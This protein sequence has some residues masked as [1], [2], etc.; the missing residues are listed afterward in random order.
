MDGDGRWRK[1]WDERLQRSEPYLI[2]LLKHGPGDPVWRSRALEP[3]R[4]AV[5]SLCVVGW[6][7]LFADG[8]VR[9]YEQISAPKMLLAG[10]WM[11]VQP[12]ASP[13]CAINFLP[14][15]LRWWDRWLRGVRNGVENE[16]PVTVFIQGSNQ[17]RSLAAWPPAEAR[18]VIWF[19]TADG[20]LQTEPTA[21]SRSAP[22]SPDS[23]IGVGAGLPNFYSTGFGLP[24]DQSDDDK[25]GITFTSAP[26]RA[27]IS[28]FGR[29]RLRLQL[30]CDSASK[31][32]VVAKLADVQP[33]DR[34]VFIT[35]GVS[36]LS[37]RGSDGALVFEFSPTSYQIAVG[38][39][40]RLT[41]S[42]GDFPRLWPDKDGSELL[43]ECGGVAAT[44]L[45]LLIATSNVGDE[46]RIEAA[47]SSDQVAPQLLKSESPQYDV[48]RDTNVGTVTVKLSMDDQLHSTDFVNSIR[49]VRSVSTSVS[50][51]NPESANFA[52]DATAEITTADGPI[53]IRAEVHVTEGSATVEGEIVSNEKTIFK[54]K[55]TV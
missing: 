9:A 25:R 26:V 45:H 18:S 17:W 21:V 32:T 11:H 47:N 49:Y 2:D 39:Q 46:T 22:K 40:L 23:T 41:I 6:R 36:S 37:A 7:D 31:G 19:T 8:M 34:S 44:E 35:A 51:A 5:P 3:T 52:G 38:H 4:I 10:P 28:I 12:H 30:N 16:S 48:T 27:P 53:H 13:L 20:G 14:I 1:V 29:A 43:V 55:W 42:N 24:I 50:A 15:M 33:S 54:R